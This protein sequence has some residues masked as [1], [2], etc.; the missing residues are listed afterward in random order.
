MTVFIQI[1]PAIKWNP[2][3]ALAQWVSKII[4]KPVVIQLDDLQKKVN[5]IE[6]RQI[7]DEKDRIRFEVLEFA[8]SCRSHKL[9]TR[10][11]FQHIVDLNDKYEKLLEQT[12]D[13]NGV[14][15]EEYQYIAG[16]YR[17]C[18]E[19]NDFLA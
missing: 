17:R 8:N 9:H 16:L 6:T 14:F 4:L 7:T 18:M 13:T 1:T 11:E 5:E 12:N 19:Q 2:L 10:D 15:S 3:T